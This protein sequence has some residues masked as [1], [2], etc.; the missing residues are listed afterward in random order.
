MDPNA[1][2]KPKNPVGRPRKHPV[3]ATN[4]PVVVTP[5]TLENN[6]ANV[7]VGGLPGQQNANLNGPNAINSAY[8][9][10]Q[11]SG[12]TNNNASSRLVPSPTVTP[13]ERPITRG[14]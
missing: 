9:Q 8:S 13:C 7:G 10:Q 6:G 5:A 3:S 12:N 1:P 2:V 11:L 14:F 4:P